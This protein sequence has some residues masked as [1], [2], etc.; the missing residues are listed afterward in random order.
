M[1]Q[2]KHIIRGGHDIKHLSEYDNEI[3]E[4]ASMKRNL[5]IS[6]F[7]KLP[8]ALR[9]L[10][11]WLKI[12]SL[13]PSSRNLPCDESEGNFVELDQAVRAIWRDLTNA[14]SS[15]VNFAD[16]ETEARQRGFQYFDRSHLKLLYERLK[17]DDS[18]KDDGYFLGQSSQRE[19]ALTTTRQENSGNNLE[20]FLIAADC[21][22]YL[23][24]F[25]EM[26]VSRTH[27]LVDMEQDDFD[28]IGFK[29]M[30]QRR[31]VRLLK[32]RQVKIK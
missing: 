26:G 6:F 18:A 30:E 1:K 4:L 9:R 10:Q 24:K 16:F 27:H 3:D 13:H 5:H 31:L 21:Y 23:S 22:I 15:K 2:T 32:E 11:K 28:K 14:K 8:A 19:N 12:D 29:R 25:K 20:D 17:Y 7:S